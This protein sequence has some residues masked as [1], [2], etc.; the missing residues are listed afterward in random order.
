MEQQSTTGAISWMVRNPVAANLVMLVLIVGG[1]TM[2][3]SIKQEVFPE[4]NLD[5]VHIQVPYPGASPEEIERGIVEA[6]EEEVRSIDD[7]KEINSTAFEGGASVF[8]ELLSGSDRNK[9]L[10]DVK[11]AIDRITSFPEDAE[12]PV[13]SLISNRRS[14]VS[15]ILFGDLEERAL[16][17]LAEKARDELLQFSDITFVEIQ[18]TRPPEISVEIP[19]SR[20]R[21]YNLTLDDVATEIRRAAVELPGGGVKTKGGEVLLRTDERREF[22]SEFRDIPI[23]SRSDGSQVALSSIAKIVDGFRDVD[24]AAYYNGKPAV[25]LVV[26][27]IGDQTPI[28]VSAQVHKY[29]AELEER[30]P[31]GV[32]TA[33]W[34]DRSEVYS[35]RMN[36]LLRNASLGL[37]LVLAILGSFLAPRLAFWVTMGIPISFFGAFLLMPVMGVSINM[38]SLFAFIISLG[39][40]VDDAIVVGENIFEY[41]QRGLDFKDAAIKGATEVK[42]PVT[43]AILT[44]IAAFMPLLFVPGVTGKIFKVI[45]MIVIAVFIISWLESLFILPAHLGHQAPPQDPKSRFGKW[46]NRTQSRFARLLHEVIHERYAP[47]CRAALKQRYFTLAIGVAVLILTVGYIKGGRINTAFFPK[48]DGDV[49]NASAV[50][51]YG[52]A[53]EDT[54]R[55][56]AKLSKAAEEVIEANGGAS[57]RRGIYTSIGSAPGGGIGVGPNIPGSGGGHLTGVQ[58]LLVPTNQ[59]EIDGLEFAEQWRK[60]VGAVAGLESLSFRYTMGPSAGASIDIELSHRNIAVLEEAATALAAKVASFAGVK[61]IDDGFAEGKPQFSFK[62]KP[63]ARSLGVTASDLARQVRAAFYGARAFRQQR[64]RDEIWV[65]VRLPEAERQSEYNIEALLIRTPQGGEIPL[66]EAAEVE[67]GRA[68]TQI[69]RSEGR[70][71]VNVSADVVEG[72][73]N[74]GKILE[75]VKAS[76]LPQLVADYPGLRYGMKG[77]QRDQQEGMA[78]LAVGFL[79]AMLV[80]YAML[81]IPFKS[82]LQPLV[83]MAAIPFGM[84][85]A[86]GGHIIMGLDLSIISMMGIVALSGVVV[87]D[88]LVLVYHANELKASGLSA[89]DAVLQAGMRRFRPIVLTSLTTFCGL[90]PMIF[91][92]SV[93]ARILIPMAVSLGFGVLFATLI[94]LLLLPAL[95]LILVDAKAIF[96]SNPTE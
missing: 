20:L 63:E 28:E 80:I 5:F 70:R 42:V 13:V 17:D 12:R 95:Y 76:I 89:Y 73:G 25:R 44:N 79:M 61:D 91:E 35:D 75:E 64:G 26:F 32:E 78:S 3:F 84:I 46:V 85:G 16:R 31:P 15:L 93:Q 50:L 19:Q 22:G 66:M 38:I 43:F 51:P 52:T 47:L 82:Y 65:M 58:V 33:V 4:F 87:N 56:A 81:A 23:I 18:G 29:Q 34:S 45:P 40:V 30:L 71:V 48:V 74:A 96:Q 10:Q 72:V 11:S 1:L 55:M 6:I 60:R 59:R 9:G 27:R 41:R 88:S 94:A 14:V 36:L 24:T 21:E 7:A 77:A 54:K 2:A 83:V 90:A 68:Y 62:I 49:I 67:R 57:I 37:V 86:I 69:T 8:V 39:I 92:S 53:V